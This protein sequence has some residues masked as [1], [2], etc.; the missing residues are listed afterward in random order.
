MNDRVQNELNRLSKNIETI[1]QLY[2]NEVNN[3]NKLIIEN[4]ENNYKISNLKNKNI[5]IEEKYKNLQLGNAFQNK[6]NDAKLEI[7]KM[8]REIND[9]IALLKK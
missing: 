7:D 5:E 1:T 8:I 6:N 9:C 4:K 2:H 3:N